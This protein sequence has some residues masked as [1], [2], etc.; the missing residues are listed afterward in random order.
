MLPTTL[1]VP[2]HD[3]SNLRYRAFDLCQ[4]SCYTIL[5]PGARHLA[6]ASKPSS[7]TS[8]TG[9]Q[10]ESGPERRQEDSGTSKKFVLRLGIEP[11][12]QDLASCAIT[13]R[14]PQHDTT[15]SRH[16]AFDVF[17]GSCY[18]GDVT[19][20]VTSP[21]ENPCTCFA[22][23]HLR[24]DI[25]QHTRTSFPTILYEYSG[26]LAGRA[27]KYRYK[28]RPKS[29]VHNES[30]GLLLHIC[31]FLFLRLVYHFSSPFELNALNAMLSV[32]RTASIVN[33]LTV[34]L[35]SQFSDQPRWTSEA[36]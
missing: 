2:Q 17:Q 33:S 11:G 34:G 18:R 21:L 32:T 6:R 4:G 10:L 5:L 20:L 28:C 16:R 29:V 15:S 27:A 26:G 13:A 1:L 30:I 8:V 36:E 22:I 31:L 23:D 24:N 19:V 3:T 9:I 35:N 7:A 14:P 25:M 12:S